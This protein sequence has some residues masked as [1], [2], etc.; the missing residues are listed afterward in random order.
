MY[1]AQCLACLLWELCHC[2]HSERMSVRSRN[3]G[4]ETASSQDL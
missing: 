1:P 3:Q 2:L 4:G